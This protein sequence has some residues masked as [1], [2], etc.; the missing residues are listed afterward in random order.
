MSHRPIA[1]VRVLRLP[2]LHPEA[3]G[4]EIACGGSTTE[5]TSIPGPMLALSREQL[6]TMAV[7]EHEIRCGGCDT[8][9]AHVQGDQAARELTDRAW[10]EL[11]VAAQRRYDAARVGRIPHRRVP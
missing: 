5:L 6:V 8:E 10:K 3:I 4:I 9:P 1:E 2:H 11:L 7:F